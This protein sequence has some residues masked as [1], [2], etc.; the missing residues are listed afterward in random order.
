MPKTEA[1]AVIEEQYPAIVGA[2]NMAK[3]LRE[4]LGGE[5]LTMFDLERIKIPSGGGIAWELLD[6]NGET[7]VSKS[8]VGII[9]FTKMVRSYWAAPIDEGGGNTPPD[10]FSP[11]AQFGIG[12]P[13]GHCAECKHSKFGSARKGNGQACSQRRLLFILRPGNSMPSVLSV[14]PTSL[15]AF[16][17]WLVQMSQ[18][19]RNYWSFVAKFELV[20]QSNSAGIEYAMI[21]PSIERELDATEMAKLQRYAA[22][23]KTTFSEYNEHEVDA[24]DEPGADG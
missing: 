18:R 20:K 22:A 9:A 4:N 12:T 23:I 10:C 8:F 7:T 13:G 15:K 1:L 2:G 17:A 24:N 14:P 21:K 3:T 11:D 6:A 16:K 5:T 19:D